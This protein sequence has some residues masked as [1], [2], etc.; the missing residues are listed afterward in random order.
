MSSATIVIPDD[1]ARSFAGEFL[2]PPDA[3]YD[4]VR[5][6]HN[7]LIDKRPAVIARATSTDDVAVA[8]ALARR[9]GLELSVR[10][11]GH[12]VAGRAVTDGGVMVD[13]STMKRIDVDSQ[14]RTVTA[15]GGVTW[16]EM[17][18]ATHE[19][20]LVVPGGVVSS[21]GIGGLTLGGGLGWTQGRFGLSIDN[22][23]AAEVV[24]A[25]GTVI[26]A[27]DED[28]ADLFWA[29]RGGGGNFGVV[30]RFTYRAH[31]LTTV[32]GGLVAYPADEAAQVLATYRDVTASAPDELSV[33]VGL[34]HTPDDAHAPIIAVPLCHCGDDEAAAEAD[35]EPLRHAGTVLADD[36][37]RIPYPAM[38]AATDPLFPRGTLNYWKQ[39]FVDEVSGGLIDVLIDAFATCPSPMSALVIE[40]LHGAAARVPIDATAFP[41][42]REGYAVLLCGQWQ[43]PADNEANISWVRDTFVALAPLVSD[44][45]YVNYMGDGDSARAAYGPQYDR[46]VD[47]KRRYDPDNLFR[48]NQNV[49]PTR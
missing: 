3:T 13:L 45:R 6:V 8:L 49:D 35:I 22:L 40:P 19:H 37:G 30:T 12:N 2:R 31:P 44:R 11:G 46:L 14:R 18:Q 7:G 24:T 26:V 16:A 27:S 9:L 21:T 32:L 36:I 4:D 25:D 15:E 41:Y 34:L 10:G 43:D 39:A 33:Q 48:L 23:L 47:V 38:N 1:L 28:H 5:R 29:L 17:D 20:G 42:R